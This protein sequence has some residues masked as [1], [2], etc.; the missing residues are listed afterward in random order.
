MLEI[1]SFIWGHQFFQIL[2]G[3]KFL[4]DRDRFYAFIGRGGIIW[5]RGGNFSKYIVRWSHQGASHRCSSKFH[6]FHGKTPLFES[7]FNKVGTLKAWS[8]ATL[9]TTLLTLLTPTQVL[10]A[11]FLRIA[12]LTEHLRWLLLAYDKCC[13]VLVIAS[14]V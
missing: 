14:F 2:P 6:K 10:F 5:D 7:L 4:S 11:K 13:L 1:F 9:L 12:F 3:L 8:P